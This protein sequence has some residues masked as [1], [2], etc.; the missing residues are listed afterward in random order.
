MGLD[1]ATTALSSR[2]ASTTVAGGPLGL[3]RKE[4]HASD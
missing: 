3:Y 1:E 4:N 2:E